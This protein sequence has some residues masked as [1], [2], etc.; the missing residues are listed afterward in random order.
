[1]EQQGQNM[2]GRICPRGASYYVWRAGDTIASVARSNHTTVQAIR[3]INE[4]MDFQTISAGTEI[5]LPS[6]SLTCQS[7]QAYTIQS[8]D[9]LAGIAQRLGITEL[10]LSERN[11]DVNANDL[12]VGDVICIPADTGTSNGG[13]VLDGTGQDDNTVTPQPIVPSRPA[14]ACPVGYS[15]RRVQAG[16]TYADLLVDLNV[17]YKAMRN[18]NPTLRPGFMVAGTP[19][20]A[21]PAG[22][23]ETCS[24]SRSY[25]IQDGDSLGVIA[26]RLNTTTGRL[27]ML[28]PTLVPTDFSQAGVMI[29]IP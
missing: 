19:Y 23:R 12:M 15:A 28:N 4:G 10:A 24:G 8:G 27:L 3:L 6:Q 1:M 20:C 11:P 17:S 29:C 9:T 7:G 16:Q 26:Q 14:L 5:C 18:A 22:T 21:P 13:P 25:A 2:T